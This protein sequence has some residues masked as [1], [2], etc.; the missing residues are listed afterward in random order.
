VTFAAVWLLILALA[1]VG[2][3]RAM[4]AETRAELVGVEAQ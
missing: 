4:V 2:G 1:G 3:W